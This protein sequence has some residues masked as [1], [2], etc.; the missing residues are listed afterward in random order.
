[1]L[2]QTGVKT[3]LNVLETHADSQP[4]KTASI[5]LE[6]G[7]LESGRLSYSELV[8]RA[9][10][11]AAWLLQRVAPG[12]RVLLLLPTGLDFV[13]A[14]LGCLYAGVIA[15]PAY[16]PRRGRSRSS[17]R[18]DRRLDAMVCN[19]TPALALI[20]AEVGAES[21]AASLRVTAITLD[22]TMDSPDPTALPELRSDTLA[23]LQYT[24]GSTGD[25]KGVCISHGN[26]LSNVEQ[27]AACVG[28]DDAPVC[29]SWLPL[30]HDM[31]LVGALLAPLSW[32]GTSVLMEPGAFM[33]KPVR[34]LQAISRYRGAASAAPSSAYEACVE[35]INE[36]ERIELDLSCW[37][38]AMN[39]SEP[40]RPRT[41]RRFQLAFEANGFRAEAMRPV[42]GMAESTLLIAGQAAGTLPRVQLFDAAAMSHGFAQQA[43]TSDTRELVACGHAW[44]P[45][46]IR[47]AHAKSG[48][49]CADGEI[50]EILVSGPSVSQ[51]YWNRPDES[52]QS[53]HARLAGD[54]ASWLRTGD[55]GLLDAGDLFISGRLKD[56]IIVQGRNLY[57]QDLEATVEESDPA[58]MPNA[59]AAFAIE[60]EGQEHV[61]VACEVR[62]TAVRGL[63]PDAVAAHVRRA[64]SEEHDAALHEIVFLLPASIPR[65]SSGKV[66]RGAARRKYLQGELDTIGQWS[67]RDSVSAPPARSGVESELELWLKERVAALSGLQAKQLDSDATFS[68]YG[69]NSSDAVALSGEL[70]D[71][72]GRRLSPTL[73][74]DFPSIRQMALQLANV[75]SGE[76]ADPWKQERAGEE[77]ALIG[78]GCRFPG[79][80]TPDEFWRLL[81]EGYDAIAASP[82]RINGLPPTGLLDQ[83]D[84]FDA[85]FWGI[86]GREAETMDPQQRLLLEAAWEAVE[87]AGIAPQSLAGSRTAVAIGI[88]TNDYARLL[89]SGSSS[90]DADPYASTGNAL[91]IAANRISHLLDLR[92]PSWSVDTACSS[93]LVALHQTCG[94]L[95]RGECDT[96]LVG[97]ANLIL[98][99]D[100]SD[101]F[102][103]T[104]MLSR[105]GVCRAFD[106][107]ANGYVRGEGVAMVLLKRLSD[108]IRDGD[109]IEAVIR[110]TA[111]NQDG[112]SNGLTAPNGP[113]QQAVIRAALQDA[114]V[115][116][117]DIS[118][119]ETHGT[120][121]P[122]GDPIELNA[123]MG[124]LEEG[125]TAEDLCWIGSVKTNLGHLEA[126]AGIAGVIKTVL[127]LRQREIVP[128]LHLHTLNPYIQMDGKPFRIAEKSK[129]ENSAGTRI[130][131]VSSFGFGGTNAHVILSEAPE[132]TVRRPYEISSSGL[133]ALSAR[134]PKALR[135]LQEI[136]AE[137]LAVH[138]EARLD[139][140]VFTV[141]RSR[142]FFAERKVVFF[143]SREDLIAKLRSSEA[144]HEQDAPE[145]LQ[146]IA[147]AYL[148]GSPLDW[149]SLHKGQSCMPIPLPTYPFE[150][151]RYWVEGC[152]PSSPLLGRRLEQLA[153]L[154][155][156]WTWECSLRAVRAGTQQETL[157]YSALVEMALSAAAEVATDDETARR[158]EVVRLK[159]VAPLVRREGR[160]ARVQAVL[161]RRPAGGFSFAVYQYEADLHPHTSTSWRMCA[162]AELKQPIGSHP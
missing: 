147:V 2:K 136:Y 133:L 152:E 84:Q 148:K 117:R 155:D 106:E 113:A 53:F 24:S 10:S 69:L 60:R 66:Q 67:R 161:G 42:Y 12:D 73:L 68:S 104:G 160:P 85:E 40:I 92:G 154:Q 116:A 41:M 122:L 15:V 111:V 83:V 20:N 146:R 112:R 81:R 95:R 51:G 72:L 1:M 30:F 119:V 48:A 103:R 35:K 63:Q 87:R 114:R 82:Q 57:P 58:L 33:Q 98:V 138:S 93:S 37:R 46:R 123:L 44:G 127:S 90:A 128:H 19:C 32:G 156:V 162:S 159:M 71:R 115:A 120:G 126:A 151:K 153:H 77:I 38:I 125:R 97:G 36:K 134:T 130:A 13:V 78:M 102:T 94:M 45:H 49:P 101:A 137:F 59:C 110:G 52:Q 21:I 89:R 139:D 124:V 64:L 105:D 145:K 50:G 62:R 61:V 5:F 65:T 16:P 107:R 91:S 34:W 141:N 150:R 149:T 100:L 74:Y 109:R 121:T 80:A 6:H 29:V 9:R 27:I 7:E 70:E 79:A 17:A 88:S 26:I 96:A 144:A 47:I 118:F 56:L 158:S 129:W 31:G 54:D 43:N 55:L 8:L 14:F 39:G 99:P 18:F 75:P 22:D 142:T 131:G 28:V 11:V 76:H 25:P 3:F 135:A 132:R 23:F 86:N 140:F 108:A 143:N 4:D 157:P